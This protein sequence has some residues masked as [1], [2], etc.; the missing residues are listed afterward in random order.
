M[1]PNENLRIHIVNIHMNVFQN[2]FIHECAW[3]NFLEGCKDGRTEIFVM[4]CR[5]TYVLKRTKKIVVQVLFMKKGNIDIFFKIRPYDW[6]PGLIKQNF[7]NRTLSRHGLTRSRLFVELVYKTNILSFIRTFLIGGFLK[8]ISLKTSNVLH[9]FIIAW[10]WH[11]YIL[12][13]Y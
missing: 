4:R 10:I 8:Y 5:R 2:R 6:L 3:K 13:Y 1:W 12:I 9:F 7:K 11:L